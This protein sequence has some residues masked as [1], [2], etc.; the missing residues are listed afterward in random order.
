MTEERRKEFNKYCLDNLCWPLFCAEGGQAIIAR[1]SSSVAW[2]YELGKWLFIGREI[3]GLGWESHL[4]SIYSLCPSTQK[5]TVFITNASP[6]TCREKQYLGI[7]GNSMKPL[8]TLFAKS[9]NF[10]LQTDGI[11][12]VKTDVCVSIQQFWVLY[13]D[14]GLK[15]V[16][17]SKR[18]IFCIFF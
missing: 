12:N 16:S 11:S 7:F 18:K 17:I 10:H 2:K 4:I 13:L 9:W 14:F 3:L 6:L 1:V 8:H 5:E 15:T